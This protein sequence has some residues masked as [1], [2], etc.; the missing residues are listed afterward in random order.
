MNG[1]MM[2]RPLLISS[3]IEH[4][5]RNHHD[6][7]IV[8]R[9][10]EG[11][12]HR[13]TYAD[14]ARRSKQL[15]NALSAL[16]VEAGDRVATLAWNGYRHVEFYFAVSGMGAVCHT[17]NPRLHPEQMAY[18]INH[19]QDKYVFIDLTFVKLLE[20]IADQLPSVEGFVIMTDR[21]HMPDTTLE[22]VWCYEELVNGHSD[23]YAWPEFDERTA[24]SLC[25]T[26]GTTGH[27]K[28]VLYS[29]R[30]TVLHS[31]AASLPDAINM[32]ESA[33]L[34][35]VVPMFHVNAWGIPYGAAMT[36][37]KLVMPGPMLDGESLTELMNQESV[38]IAAGVPTVW[39]GLL[40]HLREA[41]AKLPSLKMVIVGGA[42]APRSM[43]KEFEEDHGVELRHA[44][45]MTE[46]SPVGTVSLV[47]PSLRRASADERYAAQCKQGRSVYGVE[48][49]IV[50]EQNKVL[51]HDGV[52]FGELKVRGP[53]IAS[54]Y[55]EA[56]ESESHDD[57]G[58][59]GTGDVAT[60]DPDGYMQITDRKKDLIKS[61]GEWISSIDLENLAVA[62]PDVA[63]AAVIGVPH[64]KWDE[65]PLL[66]VMT[67]PDVSP[68]RE[69]VLDFLKDKVPAWWIPDDVVFVDKLPMG[70]TGKVLKTELRKQ[71]AGA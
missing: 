69:D 6:Q 26:S 44:W 54:G 42:A 46:M 51:P 8:S 20:A 23:E 5:A 4:A 16:G 68:T 49:K 10:V 7:E 38:T 19:A 56:D 1:L 34:L 31:Y 48:M 40:A 61:G 28:G 70:A 15:A 29:H 32:S 63:Q 64:E 66:I 60:I 22:R 33:S 47:K 17:M 18:I 57:D 67:R 52:A 55:F 35:P 2:D 71:Y 41:G 65:R 45:G 37:T 11:P 58:W 53:W 43:I 9:T 59:F 12:I 50:D 3:L 36:G 21:A 24:S 13:C 62:H 39:F 14:I 27:P 25:Y 30:S